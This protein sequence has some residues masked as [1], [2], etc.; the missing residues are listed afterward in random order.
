MS[1][2]IQQTLAEIKEFIATQTLANKEVMN[3]SE[4][5]IYAGISKSYL[6]KLTSGRALPFYR[7]ATKLIFFKRQEIDAWLLKNREATT[8]ELSVIPKPRSL[9]K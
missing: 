8:E 7:P 4:A 6:Y 5:A 2:I 3:L 9:K 1:H